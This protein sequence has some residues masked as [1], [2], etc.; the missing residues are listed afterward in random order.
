M[1]TATTKTDV[2]ANSASKRGI[3]GWRK[4]QTLRLSEYDDWC[5]DCWIT[6]LVDVVEAGTYFIKA[7]TNAAV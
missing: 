6:I 2:A 4:G 1:L 5:T 7:H 3:P